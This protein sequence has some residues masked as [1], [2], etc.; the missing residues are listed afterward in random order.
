MNRPEIFIFLVE[1]IIIHKLGTNVVDFGW[2]GG[3]NRIFF[4]KKNLN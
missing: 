2:Y 1:L 4:S 3:L